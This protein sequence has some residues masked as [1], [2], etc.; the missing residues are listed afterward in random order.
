MSRKKNKLSKFG[1][2]PDLSYLFPLGRCRLGLFD[3]TKQTDR[4]YPGLG[5]PTLY[6]VLSILAN[7]SV[8]YIAGRGV[9]KTRVINLLPDIPGTQ[10]SKW[11]TFTLEELSNYCKTIANSN[12]YV[13]NKHLVFKVEDFSTLGNYHREIF[14]TVCSKIIS[15]GN[16]THAT[17]HTKYLDVRNCKLTLLIAIQPLL[18]SR[19]CNNY[20][21]WESMSYDRFSKF[22]VLNPLRRGTIDVPL[23]PT[24]PRKIN[25]NPT[26]NQ[27]K[28]KLN[29]VISI[30]KGQVSGGRAFLYARDYVTAL[31]RFEGAKE[32]KQTHVDR[33]CKIFGPYLDSFSTLQE[34]KNLSSA[35]EV[36]SGKIN[37]LTEIA[38]SS[39]TV[40]KQKLAQ[41][42][43]VT[44]R[45]IER[46]A[47]QLVDV[48]LIEKPKPA[49][50]RLS[51]KLRKH[52]RSYEDTF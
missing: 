11:D 40:K 35:I 9:G 16:Y 24:L 3:F 27:K 4:V 20:T 12:D 1:D 46:C 29:K 8:F 17:K 28:L 34:R 50:Y 30:Y 39:K 37:L 41:N 38:K 21:Q 23:I 5:I 48:D 33:F 6:G 49:K 22:L 18:Y 51:K 47:K 32:V 26:F 44:E 15:D 2:Y 25:I 52:F 43:Y 31:A 7:K 45:H 14:L 13:E 36:N 42:L 19:L 10:V